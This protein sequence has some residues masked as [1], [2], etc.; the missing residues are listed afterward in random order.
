[1]TEDVTEDE[2][3]I[4]GPGTQ[5]AFRNALGRFATGVTVVTTQ[6]GDGPVGI[7]AN[8]FAGL[9]LDPP[10]VLWAPAKGSRRFI[11]F[12]EARGFAIHVLGT[13][14][15]AIGERFARSMRDFSGL[16]LRQS[17]RGV[18]TIAGTLACF[19]CETESVH[20][21]GDHLIIVGRVHHARYRAG[22]PL[23]FSSG[24]FGGFDG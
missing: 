7:T 22:A 19:E 9:S 14:E 23:I 11:H 1:M 13:D 5:R 3:F 18:P 12:A 16:D 4:P 15:A 2:S 17:D 21:G 6:A 10:L 20:D 8:S 24:V